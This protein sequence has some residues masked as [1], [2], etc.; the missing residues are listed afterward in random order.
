MP[1]VDSDPHSIT[2]KLVYCGP[3]GAG[4]TTNLLKLHGRL[5]DRH[6]SKMLPIDPKCSPFVES[7]HMADMQAGPERAARLAGSVSPYDSDRVAEDHQPTL[8]FD[9]LPIVLTLQPSSSLR[10]PD[11]QAAHMRPVKLILRLLAGPGQLMH[12]HTRRL[13]L[14]G[15]DGVVFVADSERPLEE[16]EQALIALRTNLRDNGLAPDTLPMVMQLNKRDA[17][18]QR[19]DSLLAGRLRG[20]RADVELVPAIARTGVGVVETLLRLVAVVWPT[21]LHEHEDVAASNLDLPWLLQELGAALQASHIAHAIAESDI[22]GVRC[23]LPAR[24]ESAT[25]VVPRGSAGRS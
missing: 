17:A 22:A 24:P 2:I 25:S 6:R 13:L 8:F 3:F 12:N 4:K 18:E 5:L 14:R 11:A 9:L 20:N 21:L 16:N 15:A 7:P 23:A 1:Q 19:T 10:A